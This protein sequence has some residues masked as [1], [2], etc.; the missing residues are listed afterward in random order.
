MDT[1]KDSQGNLRGGCKNCNCTQFETSS[2]RNQCSNC[3]C[4]PTNHHLLTPN[5][6]NVPI[7]QYPSCGRDCSFENGKF[8]DFCSKKHAILHQSGKPTSSTPKCQLIGCKKQCFLS[9]GKYFD[10]CGTTHADQAKGNPSLRK[11]PSP[12]KKTGPICQLVGCNKECYLLNGKYLDFCGNTHANDAKKDPT[13]KKIPAPKCKLVGC[14]QDCYQENG[15]YFDYCGKAH[16]KQAPSTPSSMKCHS[17]SCSKPRIDISAYCSNTCMDTHD[18]KEP[19]LHF[20]PSNSSQYKKIE[21]QFTTKWLHQSQKGKVVAILTIFTTSAL[22]NRF[23]DYVKNIVQTR[24]NLAVHGKGTEGNVHRRFHG[25]NSMKCDLGLN[26]NSKPCSQSGCATCGIIQNG[27]LLSKAQSHFSWGRFGRGLY[28]SSTSSKSNDYNDGTRVGL[29][30]KH[31][32]MFLCR[33]AIGKGH[34]A[35]SNMQSLQ[36]APPGF[37]SVLGEVGGVLNHDEV[38]VYNEGAIL[39]LYLIIYSV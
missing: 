16:A 18:R 35:T 19:H 10:F 31:K 25:T 34:K 20:L 24:P 26:Q 37:D 14:N 29:G 38:V 7:C 33:V 28:L 30:G 11:Q 17:P 36:A 12:S 5:R 1:R 15:K 3:S 13:L 39:P 4:K 21:D 32:A 23:K 27:L 2:I 22:T 8:Y 6:S 9:N